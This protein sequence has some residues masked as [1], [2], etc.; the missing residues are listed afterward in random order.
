MKRITL[1]ITLA[2]AA[3]FF[4]SCIS[5]DDLQPD[6]TEYPD[7]EISVTEMKFPAA[8]GEQF[9]TVTSPT[10]D[11]VAATLGDWVEVTP[12]SGDASSESHQVKVKALP[13]TG[14]ERELEVRFIAPTEYLSLIISQAACQTPADDKNG[15]PSN[16]KKVSVAKFL[17]APESSD[18][19][20]ELTGEITSI[21][22]GNS[23]G[24]LYIND[25]TAEVY[26]Y[27]LTNGWVGYN[28]KSF[29]S[30]GLKVGDTVTLGT[31][32]GSYNGEPQGG[33]SKVP[34]YYISHVSEN[35][36]SDESFD[37][38]SPD[39]L[40]NNA[41][42]DVSFWF[43]NNNWGQIDD[44]A[45]TAEG[46]KHTIVIPEGIGTQRW[47]GQM[48]FNN[49]GI[50]TS[51]DKK[52]DF[53][54]VLNSTADHGGVI[55]KLTQQDDDNIFFFE[56]VHAVTAYEE[57]KYQVKGIQGVDLSNAKLVLD[58]GG[59]VGGSTVVIKDIVIR[60]HK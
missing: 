52:Y 23:Y 35:N 17:A 38:S 26:I 55:I 36:P 44:P 51:A 5:V 9:L 34:A 50:V 33:G 8:G 58:F 10:F 56:D 24:N 16:L 40:W 31:L 47:Q 37:P 11:W 49:T 53:Q 45:Y 1:I 15:K 4:G 12:E 13:N 22:S 7:I 54:L 57:F 32:R 43:A 19:W 6:S 60:E 41:V 25:G 30:I 2:L 29:D 20:Y 28:D 27:G 21:V 3:L 59:G 46:N 42:I 18:V 48:I 39:N 14:S